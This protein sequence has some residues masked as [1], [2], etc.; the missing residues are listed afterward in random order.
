MGKR[1]IIAATVFVLTGAA[2]YSVAIRRAWG[3]DLLGDPLYRSGR[4]SLCKAPTPS[5]DSVTVRTDD[6]G[7]TVRSAGF[8]HAWEHRFDAGKLTGGAIHLCS[9]YGSVRIKGIDGTEGRLL[10]TMS[11]PFPGGDNAIRDTRLNTSVRSD[12]GGLRVAVWQQ[13]QGMTTFRSFMKKG[14]RPVAVNI[15]LELPRSGAYALSLVANHQ[16]VTVRNLD[17][18]GVIEGYLSPGADL[19]VGLIGSLKL[20]L[21]NEALKPDWRRDAG[22]DFQGGTTATLRPLTS[23]RVDFIL[24]KGDATV[25]IVG[26]DVGLDVIARA[27]PGPATVDIGPTEVAGVDTAGTHA[28]GV[29]YA[30]AA[31]KVQVRVTSE[32]GSVV[33]RRA[34]QTGGPK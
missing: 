9:E 6:R 29:G 3:P 11:D 15:V 8:E 34:I 13:T 16:R 31:R 14:A 2:G 33:V 1:A 21:N 18:R 28:L 22:V 7:Q 23:A 12:T 4:E 32:G 25:N 27:T 10:V 17:V 19:D 30:R 26:S 5:G 20:S 24:A